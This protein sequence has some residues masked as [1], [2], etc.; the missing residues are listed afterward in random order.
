[1]GGGQA[2]SRTERG[3]LFLASLSQSVNEPGWDAARPELTQ[4]D[5]PGDD[6]QAQDRQ[7]R[8]LPDPARVP[9]LGWR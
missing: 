4:S 6:S 2:E 8:G 3:P 9:A 7:K 1:M 5:V